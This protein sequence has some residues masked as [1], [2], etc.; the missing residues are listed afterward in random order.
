MKMNKD[1][2]TLKEIAVDVDKL[3]KIFLEMKAVTRYSTIE[4]FSIQKLSLWS[5][6]ILKKE[7]EQ[8]RKCTL[9][10]YP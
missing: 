2:F 4:E 7:R 6:D 3:I 5:N 9:K 10:N 8:V 1:I